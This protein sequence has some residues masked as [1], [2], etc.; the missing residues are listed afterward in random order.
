MS[1]LNRVYAPFML[2]MLLAGCHG[3]GHDRPTY[4]HEHDGQYRNPYQHWSRGPH[5]DH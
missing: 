2:L 4:W 5:T 1:H 3:A